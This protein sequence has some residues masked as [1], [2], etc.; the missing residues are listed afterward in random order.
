MSVLD[1]AREAH[2]AYLNI[3]L[4]DTKIKNEILFWLETDKFKEK[5]SRYEVENQG[6]AIRLY[7][8]KEKGIKKC[9]M[10]K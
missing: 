10:K 9:Q 3:S 4:A 5:I 6:G 8:K 2:Q 7:L 1:I